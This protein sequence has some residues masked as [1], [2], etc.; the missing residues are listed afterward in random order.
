MTPLIYRTVFREMAYLRF[1]KEENPKILE[2]VQRLWEDFED[3]LQLARSAPRRGALETDEADG[4]RGKGT[5]TARSYRKTQQEAAMMVSEKPELAMPVYS[6]Y[7]AFLAFAGL[8]HEA[9][10]I[11]EEARAMFP[12]YDTHCQEARSGLAAFTL[13]T[14]PARP[15]SDKA[16]GQGPDK[17]AH[18]SSSARPARHDAEH[19][20]LRSGVREGGRGLALTR[21]DMR[22]LYLGEEEEDGE[23][24][25]E[26]KAR[27]A[28]RPR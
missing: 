20:W 4:G 24:K 12:S 27:Q 26:K 13:A 5:D 2:H 23:E 14:S 28:G 1:T 10:Q 9:A 25:K 8:P 22:D 11:E 19:K 17:L 18:T 3:L 21:S 15:G 6:R 16:H 7:A